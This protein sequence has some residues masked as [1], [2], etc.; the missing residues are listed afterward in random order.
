M[1]LKIISNKLFV[2]FIILLLVIILTITGVVI[3]LKSN[4][5]HLNQVNS[6]NGNLNK[7]IVYTIQLKNVLEKFAHSEHPDDLYE[8][9]SNDLTKEIFNILSLLS[10]TNSYL[11][12]Y[13]ISEQYE[14]S[15]LIKQNSVLISDFETAFYIF[16]QNVIQKG[17]KNYGYIHAII[18]NEEKLDIYF[19]NYPE[20]VNRLNEL[21]NLTG[22]YLNNE[23]QQ[24]AD[25]FSVK[26]E[27]LKSDILKGNTLLSSSDEIS[28]TAELLSDYANNFSQTVNINKINGELYEIG[29]YSDLSDIVKEIISNSSELSNQLF[30]Q[31]E[32]RSNKFQTGIF[33]LI[34]F[35]SLIFIISLVL[36]YQFF[37]GKLKRIN[38]TLSELATVETPASEFFFI[39]N[40]NTIIQLITKLKN[41]LIRKIDFINELTLKNYNVEFHE[42]DS[43][44]ALGIALIK[45]QNQL[46]ESEIK[47]KTEIEE[48]ISADRL[49]EGI[50]K[51]GRIL[52]RNIGN[53]ETLTYELI[54]ELVQ[55]LT[56]EIGGFYVS[57]KQA[58]EDILVLRASYAFSE[59]K[60]I[61]KIIP[62]GEG[63][64][65]TCAVDKS[66][67]YFDKVDE[68]YIKII[69]G[70]GFT[71]PSSLM[72]CPIY[73]ENDVL[74][75]IEL[76]SVRKFTHE[77]INFVETLAEDIAY[78]LSYLLSTDQKVKE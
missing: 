65:G 48:R 5:N 60:L 25:L 61:Q 21:K 26:V 14:L 9:E 66:T 47:N 12:N 75:V 42:E 56:A 74:G 70:F 20:L 77:D 45:F 59:K 78:T 68:D 6:F 4:L 64:V 1:K 27:Q 32:V 13:N 35:S 15:P 2:Q 23:N 69:S 53:I 46:K 41:H 17:N 51:F 49:K 7:T 34:I 76:A 36:L 54:S 39:D 31:V 73:V 11:R 57:D 52:R 72:I 67:F 55:F 44:D 50:A 38:R 28:K 63:L 62:F 40:Y 16:V 10:E 19:K 29:I 58:G 30:Y 3:Y 18:R 24:F 33:L 43:K 71:K 8:T 37:I 22:L